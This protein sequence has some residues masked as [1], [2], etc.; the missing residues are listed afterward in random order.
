MIN[1]TI[2]EL[3]INF[4]SEDPFKDSIND[5]IHI[6]TIKRNNRKCITI[7]DHIDKLEDLIEK[8][9]FLKKCKKILSCNGCITNSEEHG[10]IMQFQGDKRD[11]LKNIFISKYSIKDENIVLHGF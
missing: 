10:E 3:I 9:S 5:K 1:I 6:R 11:E 8:K 2:S 7:I 4:A